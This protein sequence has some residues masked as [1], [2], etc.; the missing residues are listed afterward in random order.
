MEISTRVGP[1]CLREIRDEWWQLLARCGQNEPTLSPA[2]VLSWWDTFGGG[3]RELRVAVLR[4]GGRLVG[5]APLVARHRRHRLLVPLRRLELA[6]S[7]EAEQDEVSS[8]YIGVL[9][10]KGCEREVAR[11]LAGELANRSFDEFVIPKMNA[12]DP[13]AEALVSAFRAVGWRAGLVQTSEAPYAP[14]PASWEQYLASL[15]SRR[16]HTVRRSERDLAAWA[17]APPVLH[18]AQDAEGLEQGRRI[19]ESL[20]AE[21]WRAAGHDGAFAST[22][23]SRFHASVMPVLLERGMLE[24]V[25]LEARGEPV[26]VLYNLVWNDKVYNYQSGRRM[27][28]PDPLRPGLAA[29]AMAIRRAIEL[30]RREYDFLGTV[31]RYKREFATAERPLVTLEA[32]RPGLRDA[33]RRL[34]DRFAAP[35]RPIS[36]H[37]RVAEGEPRRA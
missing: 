25:W 30:G 18:V 33:A 34:V 2:W 12:E 10:E 15:P 21:R 31:R 29:H 36:V 4:E 19:L 9:A 26:A 14:L 1:E 16:R 24:L 37:F 3:E 35:L 8:E 20:H 23:F 11:T 13:M 17:G 5:L 28:L 6:C 7:G 32:A 22:T 27:D